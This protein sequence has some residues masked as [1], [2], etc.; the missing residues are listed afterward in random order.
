MLKQY[1][2]SDF[3]LIFVKTVFEGGIEEM[4]IDNSVL[5]CRSQNQIFV[6]CLDEEAGLL[7]C[8]MFDNTESSLTQL[9]LSDN[10]VTFGTNSGELRAFRLPV[11]A[12][13]ETKRISSSAILQK[14]IQP[15]CI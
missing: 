12:L 2:L 10:F 13:I 9:L 6:F 7:P 1:L 4:C 3:R 8:F 15:N 11:P 5:V 14:S